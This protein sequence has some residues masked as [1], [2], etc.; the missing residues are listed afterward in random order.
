MKLFEPRDDKDEKLMDAFIEK[1][2]GALEELHRCYDELLE[3][4]SKSLCQAFSV[5]GTL[6]EV[7]RSLK[8]RAKTVID[9]VADPT[10]KAF[11]LRLADNT[12]SDIPW[13]ESVAS[14]VVQKPPVNWRDEDRA[15][16]DVTLLKNARLFTHL[17]SLAFVQ[18]EGRD[19]DRS[20]GDNAIRVGITTKNSAE[21][22]R[23]VFLSHEE[24][25]HAERLQQVVRKVLAEAGVNGQ[26]NVAIAAM[27]Q[28]LQ[29]MFAR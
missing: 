11:V 29:E 19:R 4:V 20:Q 26:T 17:E 23:V 12:L 13:L 6:P 15:K 28:L 18:D 21:T 27:A 5:E 1:L 24:R 3:E 9:W 2:R 7:A 14:L 25:E 16:Y 10:L 22:E 8:A